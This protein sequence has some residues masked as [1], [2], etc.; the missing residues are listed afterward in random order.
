MLDVAMG[1]K[2]LHENHIV[3]GDLKGASY[4]CQVPV[5]GTHQ[6]ADEHPSYAFLSC[7]CC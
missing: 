2:Y 6:S 4:L 3:H 7:L 1:V 5:L